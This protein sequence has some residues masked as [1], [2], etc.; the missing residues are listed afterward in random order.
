MNPP[1]VDSLPGGIT[2]VIHRIWLGPVEPPDFVGFGERWAE[3]HQGW[4]VITW[5]DWSVPS[6][7]NQTLFDDA[8]GP[9]HRA[10]ILRL[11]LLRRYGGVYVDTDMEPLRPLDEL[12]AHDQCAF[13]RED[14]RWV[15]TGIVAATRGHP[16]IEHLCRAMTDR[17]AAM[18]SAPPNESLG[19]KWITYEL[20][21]GAPGSET[22]TVYPPQVFYPYHFTEL[23]RRN[24]RF[25]DAYAVHHWAHSWT[26]AL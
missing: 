10:D 13:G 4:R 3:L 26:D 1:V 19:P 18:R 23:H 14:D 6:L 9:A 21:R 17:K 16:F 15:G 12:L 25:D 22:V 7:V 8:S 5:R 11:E 24:E 20:G 2:K